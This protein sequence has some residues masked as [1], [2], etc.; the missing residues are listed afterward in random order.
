MEWV[1]RQSCNSFGNLDTIPP[2]EYNGQ[3]Y[4]LGRLFQGRTAD[5][6]PDPTMSTLLESQA[7]QPP[8]YIDTS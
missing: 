1:T 3:S 6:Y 2:Y 4:P 5:Y 7:V 8:V